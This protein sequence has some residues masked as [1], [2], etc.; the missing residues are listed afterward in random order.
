MKP[1]RFQAALE[2]FRPAREARDE[3][4]RVPAYRPEQGDATSRASTGTH[5]RFSRSAEIVH[6]DDD[7]L[8]GTLPGLV[9]VVARGQ[10]RPTFADASYAA[11]QRVVARDG[12]AGV[13]LFIDRDQ[14]PFDDLAR[15]ALKDFMQKLDASCAGVA[16]CVDGD[17]FLAAT[18]RS[19]TNLVVMSLRMSMRVTICASAFDGARWL[20]PL[21]GDSAPAGLGVL[22][23]GA[24]VD[25]MRREHAAPR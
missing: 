2:S 19:V 6:R 21:L 1:N 10:L 9:V 13:L 5:P 25:Q 3:T 20:L 18:K 14:G 8:V 16:L 15:T 22:G 17:G 24:A 4:G 11:F 7:F 12:L 23:V